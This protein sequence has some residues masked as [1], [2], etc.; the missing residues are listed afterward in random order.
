ML[1][2]QLYALLAAFVLIFTASPT[3]A[4]I[5]PLAFKGV[6]RHFAEGQ[7]VYSPVLGMIALEQGLIHNLRFYGDFTPLP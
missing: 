5:T 2:K 1:K 3:T 6:T 7:E 4:R